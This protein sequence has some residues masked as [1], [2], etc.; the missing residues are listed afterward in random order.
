MEIEMKNEAE[1]LREIARLQERL[2]KMRHPDDYT[3]DMEI[4]GRIQHL[5]WVLGEE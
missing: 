2:Q 1:I 5:K 4:R 3:E